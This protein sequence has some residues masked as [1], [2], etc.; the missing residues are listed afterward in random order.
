MI[1]TKKSHVNN[2]F[3]KVF[4]T[5]PPKG[6]FTLRVFSFRYPNNQLSLINKKRLCRS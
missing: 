6:G 3:V 5:V 2:I 1:S 4:D